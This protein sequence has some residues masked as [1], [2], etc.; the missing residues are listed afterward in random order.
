[1]FLEKLT[2]LDPGLTQDDLKKIHKAGPYGTYQSRSCEFIRGKFY[3]HRVVS[4]PE[5]SK[6]KQILVE[7]FGDLVWINY[8]PA[9]TELV[10]C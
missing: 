10:Y 7:S 4:T 3:D 5:F 6:I 1:M 9:Q 2:N 8:S